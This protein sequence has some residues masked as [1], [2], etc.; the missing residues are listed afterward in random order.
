MPGETVP[1]ETV[2]EGISHCPLST[3]S[4]LPTFLMA[5]ESPGR[6]RSQALSTEGG[7]ASGV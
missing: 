4:T 3:S 1:V 7:V 6:G 2:S 5:S